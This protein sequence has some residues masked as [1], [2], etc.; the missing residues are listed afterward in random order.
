MA[1]FGSFKATKRYFD[2]EN[3]PY[4]FKAS[5]DFT[6]VQAEILEACGRTLYALEQAKQEPA[7][8]EQKRFVSVCRG[9]VPA[10]NEFEKSW[11][12]YREA[13]IRKGK[14]FTMF[15]TYTDGEDDYVDDSLDDDLSAA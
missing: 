8:D 3:F 1:D 14:V 12:K 9:E 13:L 2:D 11:V 6:R 7:N 5:G 15:S 10:E 4:G